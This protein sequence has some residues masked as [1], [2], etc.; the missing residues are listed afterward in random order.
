MEGLVDSGIYKAEIYPCNSCGP[1]PLFD[2][3][4]ITAQV[5]KAL[6][7]YPAVVYSASPDP[8]EFNLSRDVLAPPIARALSTLKPEL[9][10]A[11]MIKDTIPQ[12][13]P[14]GGGTVFG[15]NGR[16]EIPLYKCDGCRA[17]FVLPSEVGDAIRKVDPVHRS[18]VAEDYL[19]SYAVDAMKNAYESL[20]S[21]KAAQVYCFKE[22]VV[23][24]DFSSHPGRGRSFF[25]VS[26]A[27][28]DI[29]VAGKTEKEK[30]LQVNDIAGLLDL[31]GSE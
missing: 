10:S 12:F 26:I 18:S 7:K 8:K 20:E 15:L 24:V 5:L 13:I 29:V 27:F 25:R 6:Q 19:R 3:K 16:A 28:T 22:F 4:D 1:I 31:E 30:D 17:L 14:A 9:R 11:K 21:L 2:L 23:M